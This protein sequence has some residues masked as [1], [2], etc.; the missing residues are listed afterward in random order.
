MSRLAGFYIAKAMESVAAGTVAPAAPAMPPRRAGDHAAPD[1][2]HIP[3]RR[4]LGSH[5]VAAAA[6]RF[7][8][9]LSRVRL[10]RRRLGHPRL[11]PPNPARQPSAH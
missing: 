8:G 3:G 9:G 10:G 2:N 5:R 7:I 6:H 11:P 1:A 4:L